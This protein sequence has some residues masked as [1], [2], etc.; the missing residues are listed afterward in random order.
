MRCGLTI[1]VA[2]VLMASLSSCSFKGE[3]ALPIAREP[4]Y[5]EVKSA[6]KNWKPLSPEQLEKVYGE[7]PKPNGVFKNDAEEKNGPRLEYYFVVD[8]RFQVPATIYPGGKEDDEPLPSLGRPLDLLG[9]EKN[10]VRQRY[11]QKL[12][13]P[14]R[15]LTLEL[16]PLGLGRFHIGIKSSITGLSGASDGGLIN[17]NVDRMVRCEKGALKGFWVIDGKTL[18]GWELFVDV[19]TGN[20]VVHSPGGVFYS[21]QPLPERYH[22]F[23]RIGE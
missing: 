21:P 9:G 5:S 7:C 18:L 16:R 3:R 4:S 8:D 19:E 22:R 2:F 6:M 11:P 1:L 17:F 12:A 10:G 15:G 14:E 23:Q 13:P 20:I